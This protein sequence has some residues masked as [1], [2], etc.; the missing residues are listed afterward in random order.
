MGSTTVAIVDGGEGESYMP[1]ASEA[2]FAAA[3]S[4]YANLGNKLKW[5]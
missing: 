2:R 5:L 3:L 4:H 1:R